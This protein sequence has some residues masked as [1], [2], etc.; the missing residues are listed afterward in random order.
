MFRPEFD[1]PASQIF[2]WVFFPISTSMTIDFY[3]ILYVSSSSATKEAEGYFLTIFVSSFKYTPKLTLAPTPK[4]PY[5]CGLYEEDIYL[6]RDGCFKNC[7]YRWCIFHNKPAGWL[8]TS[9]YSFN[10]LIWKTAIKRSRSITSRTTP[11]CVITASIQ[12]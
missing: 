7:I 2:L 3:Y 8:T 4:L 11:R 9:N 12:N 10:S 6:N 1:S 5:L